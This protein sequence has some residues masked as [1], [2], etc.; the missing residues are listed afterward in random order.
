MENLEVSME[1]LGV[2]KENLGVSIENLGSPLN[3][4]LTNFSRIDDKI[5]F[6]CV[7]N[8]KI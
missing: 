2:S 7:T 8:K 4:W 6:F 3:I 5:C 1:N